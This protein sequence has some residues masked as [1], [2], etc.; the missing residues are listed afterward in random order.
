MSTNTE[1]LTQMHPYE[2]I[3]TNIVGVTSLWLLYPLILYTLS[4]KRR[5]LTVNIAALWIYICCIISYIMW[6]DYDKNSK[7]YTLDIYFARG[8][9][10]FLL[11]IS[12]FIARYEHY[13]EHS[14]NRY[15]KLLLPLGVC[16]FYLLTCVLHDHNYNELSAWSHLTFRFIGFW[17]TYIV[18]NPTLTISRFIIVSLTYWIYIVYHKFVVYTFKPSDYIDAHREYMI[19]TYEL[20]S[21]IVFCICLF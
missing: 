10:C 6:K 16:S 13:E 7:L 18:F 19:G 15:A 9:F 1:I 11:Y 5:Q 12:L 17:W 21:L 8:T 14:L 4:F 3:Y 20:L 2:P